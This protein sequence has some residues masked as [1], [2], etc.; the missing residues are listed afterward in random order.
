MFALLIELNV[1]NLPQAYQDTKPAQL[2]AIMMQRIS[3]VLTQN[4]Q[5]RA[6]GQGLFLGA[7]SVNAVDAILAAQSLADTL[8]SVVPA[9]EQIH[10]LDI[11][12]T[13]DLQPLMVRTAALKAARDIDAIMANAPLS[14]V[15]LNH[16]EQGR[17]IGDWP[18][19]IDRAAVL[20][21]EILTPDTAKENL[22]TFLQEQLQHA[23]NVQ[24]KVQAQTE[25][26]KRV[27]DQIAASRTAH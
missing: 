3:H 14:N 8:D 10:L 17:D 20:R 5:F 6:V 25:Q 23:Q 16:L 12:S 18:D 9:I 1:A 15:I 11:A 24:E 21:K 26:L 27:V 4:E 7:A 22:V 2:H 19:Q 13:S